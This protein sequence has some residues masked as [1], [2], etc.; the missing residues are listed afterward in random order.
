VAVPLLKF[1]AMDLGAFRARDTVW[2]IK[3][4]DRLI[5]RGPPRL[6]GDPLAHVLSVQLVA[7]RKRESNH[8]NLWYSLIVIG[9]VYPK[10]WSFRGGY[11][12]YRH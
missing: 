9:P 12:T 2:W 6:R 10:L 3:V 11:F 1:A 8:L 4:L 7:R 5:Q